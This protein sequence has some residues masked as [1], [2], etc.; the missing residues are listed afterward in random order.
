MGNSDDMPDSQFVYSGIIDNI[1][2]YFLLLNQ[3]GFFYVTTLND[4]L[5]YWNVCLALT[6]IYGFV[7]Q[8]YIH[9]NVPK[10]S[11][12]SIV[13]SYVFGM[14]LPFI[15][16]K[17]KKMNTY[18]KYVSIYILSLSTLAILYYAATA[19]IYTNVAHALGILFGF[20]MFLTSWLPQKVNQ[21]ENIQ[22]VIIGL[23]VQV[24]IVLFGFAIV[25]LS[26]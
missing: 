20:L 16:Y 23:G 17:W 6:F 14:M 7:Q 3:F 15:I 4:D 9:S 13:W 18:S 24:L 2:N 12:I 5:F 25:N 10:T 8:I 19:G 1:I 22:Y 11:G 26:K 21:Y